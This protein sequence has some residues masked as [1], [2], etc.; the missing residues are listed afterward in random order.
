MR[1]LAHV[2][3]LTTGYWLLSTVFVDTTRSRGLSC[4]PVNYTASDPQTNAVAIIP[5][6]YASTRL[7]GKP[8]LEIAG[9][10]MILWVM[11]RAQEAR[12]VAHAICATA[13]R[14]IYEAVRAAGFEALM[15]REDH[16][17]G[18]DRLAEAAAT[19]DH[20]DLIVN[21]QADEP[22]IST[23]TIELAVDELLRS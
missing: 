14:R 21:V 7:P 6:R 18:S 12:N 17:S 5:A 16:A 4:C 22:L 8:L 15:T 2:F 11:E 19:L 10:P 20:A 1:A 9:R 3:L 13:D 23:R